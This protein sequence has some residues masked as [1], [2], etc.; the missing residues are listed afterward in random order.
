[1]C[2]GRSRVDTMHS[3]SPDA[4][5]PFDDTYDDAYYG[6]DGTDYGPEGGICLLLFK[7]VFLLANA[8]II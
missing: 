3:S 5:R 4:G 8:K 7:F 6:A 2:A 1:M